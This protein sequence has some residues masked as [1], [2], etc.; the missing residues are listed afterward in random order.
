MQAAL[1]SYADRLWERRHLLLMA[2]CMVVAAVVVAAASAGWSLAV[3]LSAVGWAALW[4]AVPDRP[5]AV[6]GAVQ[7]TDTEPSDTVQTAGSL[8]LPL[9]LLDGLPDAALVLDARGFVIAGNPAAQTIAPIPTGRPLSHWLRAPELLA[10]AESAIASRAQRRSHVRL[11]SPVERSLDVIVTPAATTKGEAGRVVLVTLRDL[12]EQEQLSR[13]RMEFVANASHELRTPLAS[14]RG[15]VETLQDAAKNDPAAQA[16]FLGIMQTQAERMS[17]LIDDLLSLSRIEMR[18]HVAPTASIDLAVVV[19]DAVAA[20]RPHA[21]KSGIILDAPQESAAT[22]VTGDRDELMQVA[23]NLI[24]NAIKYG[25]KGGKVEVAIGREERLALL[26]V[27]DDGIGIAP[28]HLP[29][30][31]ERFYRVSAK[32]SKERGGTGLGLAIVK[33]IVNRHRGELRITST[34]GR[35]S[36][37]TAALP[38]A[39][40]CD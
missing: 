23:Q 32:D 10:A 34:L 36:T 27:T 1:A 28:E 7:R 30:L 38:L 4:P 26:Q 12:T 17:R 2:L 14:L 40:G 24:Q 11:Y 39:P 15:F 20:L 19:A 18:E 37:F 9:S 25:R 5:A 6:A 29:R 8:L 31:T 22:M 16:R 3:M 13:M 35:G 21:E 33:H